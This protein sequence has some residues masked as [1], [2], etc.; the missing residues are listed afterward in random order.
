[1]KKYFPIL[2]SVMLFSGFLATQIFFNITNTSAH[3]SAKDKKLRKHYE[4]VFADSKFQ[5]V[6]GETLTL[7]QI[8]A[9]IVVLNFWA[10]WCV[11]CKKEFPS[12]EKL[13]RHYGKDNVVVIGINSDETNQMSAIRKTIEEYDI[14]FPI[15]ADKEDFILRDFMVS[16]I[17]LTLIFFQEKVIDVSQGFKDFAAQELFDTFEGLL[18]QEAH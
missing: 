1:M 4:T 13:Y 11:P 15:V 17:P 12:L 3:L 6:H 8:K 2:V 18:A 5:T 9:P 10:S 16:S 14:T 7:S